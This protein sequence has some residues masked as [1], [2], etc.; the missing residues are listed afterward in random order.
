M[1]KDIVTAV[2]VD[3]ADAEKSIKQLRSEIKEYKKAVENAIV[4]SDEF[5]TATQQLNDAQ[6]ELQRALNMTKKTV[7]NADGSYNAL[8]ATMSELRKEW[9][10][11]NDEAKRDELG[12]QIDKI[13]N[14]LKELDASVGNNQRNVGN[15]KED[16]VDAMKEMQQGSFDFG[17]ELSE[18]NKTT[19]VT[20]NTLDGVGKIASGVASGFAA[21]QGVTAL[22]GIENE[23]LE[24]SLVKVQS[25]MA[26]AQGIGGMKGLVEGAGQLITAFRASAMASKAMETQ[27]NTTTVAMT[28]S[29]TATNVATAS[30]NTFKA[31]LISTGVGALIVALGTLIGYL[32]SLGEEAFNSKKNI[33]DLA[34]SFENFQIKMSKIE[35]QQNF[36]LRLLGAGGASDKD[37]LEKTLQ[38]AKQNK[39]NAIKQQ[40]SILD[41]F[42]KDS[43]EYK[44][45]SEEVK[46]YT[47]AVRKANEDLTVYN[48]KTLYQ[49]EQDRK[50]A[51]EEA[52]KKAQEEAN[53]RLAQAKQIA[54]E[55]RKAT[56]DTK[57]EELAELTRIY[58]EK[59]KL[60]I[61]EG[62][63][64][65][66]L[67]E[68]YD[69]A[70]KEIENK[71]NDI[72]SKGVLGG[73]S[74][75]L[76]NIT[77][78]QGNEERRINNKYAIKQADATSPLDAIQLEI[79]KTLELQAIRQSAFDEQ[80]KQIE[81]ILNAELEKDILT[82]EQE[83]QL[84][85]QY[86]DIQ[87]TKI[88]VTEDA[89]TQIILLEK[90]RNEELK[91]T[92]QEL[93]NNI[94]EVVTSALSSASQILSAIESTI[95]TSTQEGFERSKQLRTANAVMSTLDGIIGAWTSAQSLPA[96]FSYIL[97][98]IMASA[99][100]TMGALQVSEIQKTK[101]DGSS[102]NI[103]V[104][105]VPNVSM[106]N[107]I[108][109][110]YTKELLTDTET[111]NMNKSQRV[112]VVES[113]ITNT[114][115][116]V[117][118]KESNATF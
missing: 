112:Y 91:Y 45:I 64:I 38:Y 117:A 27:T 66:N 71:Y 96:P 101:M 34:T 10:A 114:Q 85:K 30:L 7:E 40:Q 8:Q 62:I 56:I 104:S 26:I 75:S 25:A 12:K 24:K 52:K 4:G 59:K 58:E 68:Q 15:Y 73:L 36:N 69:K 5:A 108:P 21:V 118:V 92:N 50:K 87:A 23:N 37:I 57:E 79:D 76:S 35:V 113:D 51:Q 1:A 109:V 72:S 81:T 67:T 103:S 53:Q 13:N 17:K 116:D 20:R 31:T 19:E 11:T 28:T 74:T 82:A 102:G 78:A 83:E 18:V 54:E 94:K 95:D 22:L 61:A 93:A 89:N 77:N 3:T 70:S 55:A 107:T 86:A 48:T 65:S 47:D 42:G 29:A 97:G 111:I 14:Q 32:I 80:L 106:A 2:K 115:N 46:K 9:K 88:A 49:S 43:E 16:F 90:Q 44:Q 84:R 100:A 60:L 110:A 98:G 39:E 63:D 41:K 99:T 6:A 33:D 105:A